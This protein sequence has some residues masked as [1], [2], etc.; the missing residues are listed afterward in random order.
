MTSD[1]NHN[2]N[3]IQAERYGN[4]MEV[5]S[6]PYCTPARAVNLGDGHFSIPLAT[7]FPSRDKP[8]AKLA[9]ASRHV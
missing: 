8:K 4:L 5:D 3:I 2:T 1:Q 7:P 6:T 9:T